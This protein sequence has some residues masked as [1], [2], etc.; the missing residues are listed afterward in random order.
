M[1]VQKYNKYGA[2]KKEYGGR[3]YHSKFEAGGARDYDILLKGRKIADWKPQFKISLDVN[4]YHIC[5]YILDFWV[6]HLDGT[7]ELVEYKGFA[8]EIWRMKWKLLEALFGEKY[9]LTLIRQ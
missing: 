6:K 4:G 7:E 1:Y 8:T 9:K 3:L 5:N 2:K